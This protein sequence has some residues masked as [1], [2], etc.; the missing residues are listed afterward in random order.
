[1]GFIERIFHPVVKA[2]ERAFT[3]PG[4]GGQEAAAQQ[5]QAAQTAKLPAVPA[6]PIAPAAPAAQTL[7]SAGQSPGAKKMAQMGT[8]TMLGAAAAGAGPVQGGLSGEKATK[9]LIGA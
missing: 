3:P 4:T 6:A 8:S 5:A 9:K 1:M 2:V 7:F